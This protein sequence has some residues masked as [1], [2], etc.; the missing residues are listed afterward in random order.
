MTTIKTIKDFVMSNGSQGIN[1]WI[2][3]I[4]K[5]NL[6]EHESIIIEC[7]DHFGLITVNHDADFVK[8]IKV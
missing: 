3:L 2:E 5:N 6:Q 4:K 8:A 7:A 1:Q